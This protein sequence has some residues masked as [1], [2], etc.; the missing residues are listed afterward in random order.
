[1]SLFGNETE[2]IQLK[3]YH[4]LLSD[5]VGEF[6]FFILRI[7]ILGNSE[8]L[9]QLRNNVMGNHE[10]YGAWCCMVSTA[11]RAE[12]SRNGFVFLITSALSGNTLL[13]GWCEG[14]TGAHTPVPEMTSLCAF[15]LSFTSPTVTRHQNSKCSQVDI[16]FMFDLKMVFSVLPKKNA[17]C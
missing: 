6:A 15:I 12:L 14:Q 1:M 16:A 2:N 17:V 3:N 5:F 8:A 4:L 10:L 11:K 9:A 7:K 13:Y